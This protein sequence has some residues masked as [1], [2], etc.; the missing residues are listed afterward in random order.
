MS[1]KAPEKPE[2]P[3]PWRCRHCGQLEVAPTRVDYP[4]EVNYDGRLIS[5][6]AR[7]MEIP[8]CGSCGEK[9]ITGKVDRQINQALHEFLHLLTPNEIRD[10]IDKLGLTQKEVAARLGIA[11]ATLSRWLNETVVQSRAMDNL[12]RLFLQVPEVRTVLSVPA[13][14]STMNI[15]STPNALS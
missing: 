6:V 15:S 14:E 11:E 2:S 9:L 7:G 3:F 13:I 12:L 1:K 5:F 10:G 4:I 8:I